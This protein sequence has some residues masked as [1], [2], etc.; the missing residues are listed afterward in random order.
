MT[1]GKVQGKAKSAVP[2]RGLKLAL[3]RSSAGSRGQ[4]EQLSLAIKINTARKFSRIFAEDVPP[5][6]CL[7]HPIDGPHPSASFIASPITA[8]TAAA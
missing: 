3:A 1:A 4:R 2:T 5:A 6:T 8:S 7:P